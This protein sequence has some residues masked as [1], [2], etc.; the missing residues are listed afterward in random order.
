[1]LQSEGEEPRAFA[2]RLTNAGDTN[3][4]ALNGKNKA[5]LR[6]SNH[7][8]MVDSLAK[9][10]NQTDLKAAHQSPKQEVQA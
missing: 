7:H 8:E 5:S 3:L 4:C 6:V 10:T 2:T 9:S 1:M